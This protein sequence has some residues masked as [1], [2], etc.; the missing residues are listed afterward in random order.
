MMGKNTAIDSTASDRTVS[1]WR[2]EVPAITE[3]FHANFRRHAYPIHTHTVWTLLIL[4]EG[5]LTFDV[6]R[7]N[8][9]TVRSEVVLLPPHVP[10]DGRT[11]APQGFRKRV[12]YLTEDVLDA[13]LIGS[14]TERPAMTDALLWDRIARLH[15]ALAHPGDAFEADSR[16][17]LIVDRLTQHLRR[18]PAA[19]DSR[20]TGR[21]PAGQLRDLLDERVAAGL[22]LDEAARLLHADP[23]HLVRAFTRQFGIPP[24]LYLTGRRVELARRMLLSGRPAGTVAAD[25]GLYDQSHLTRHFKRMLGVTPGDF[26][27]RPLPPGG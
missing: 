24:H 23:S 26:A 14:A 2:P 21:G 6:E 1:A 16:L 7:R 11:A 8:H 3:V 17:A 12:I 18:S 4:D 19:T 25:V 15:D 20:R 10:H 27:R 13:N 9:V 5:V 22:R